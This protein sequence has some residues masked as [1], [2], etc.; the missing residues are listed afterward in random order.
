[1]LKMVHRFEAGTL[2]DLMAPLG[3]IDS[4]EAS[5]FKTLSEQDFT[6]ENSRRDPDTER[7]TVLR[8]TTQATWG[9]DECARR[10][11]FMASKG[12]Q[13]SEAEHHPAIFT[14]LR[15]A[16]PEGA[17]PEVDQW[18]EGMEKLS[19]GPHF[20]QAGEA[21]SLLQSCL[22]GAE[23]TEFS[24]R[25]A[26]V[27]SGHFVEPEAL[28][29]VAR[30]CPPKAESGTHAFLYIMKHLAKTDLDD[31]ALGL[32]L[33]GASKMGWVTAQEP[34]LANDLA[35][36][37]ALSGVPIE[38][39]PTVKSAV[40]SAL[41]EAGQGAPSERSRLAASA[42]PAGLLE[43][44]RKQVLEGEVDIDFQVDEI[45]VGSIPLAFNAP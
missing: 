38:H 15:T 21:L 31:A 2:A 13:D 1:M 36:A 39:R 43:R 6:I 7:V 25:N 30:H 22:K 19:P 4:P 12:L 44:L 34:L 37:G 26:V 8:A 17:H 42:D 5:F 14:A 24:P 10:I 27:F 33:S 35:L 29:Q 11:L 20:G 45:Q 28:A 3:E 41:A 18:L 23:E 40:E 9:D 32:A 16:Y